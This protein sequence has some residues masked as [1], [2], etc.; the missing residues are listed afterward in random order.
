MESDSVAGAIPRKGADIDRAIREGTTIWVRAGIEVGVVSTID[1]KRKNSK[2]LMG[3]RSK[4]FDTT[5]SGVRLGGEKSSVGMERLLCGGGGS[6]E[7][8]ITRMTLLILLS[9]P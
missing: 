8:E 4:S 2:E 3:R 9:G 7:H 5:L 1:I 6:D